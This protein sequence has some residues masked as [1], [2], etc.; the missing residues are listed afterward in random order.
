M[1]QDT[2][3]YFGRPGALDTIKL[4]K[5]G[6]TATRDRVSATYKLAGGGVR[7]SR[8]LSG[9]RTYTL[10]YQTLDYASAAVL[11]AYHCGANGPGPFVLLDPGQRNMLT[12]NQS[13]ACGLTNDTSNFSVSGSGGSITAEATTVHRGT[14]S[15][16]WSFAVTNPASALLSLD[17]P[18]VDWQGIP[19]AIRQHSFGC[20][21][22]GGGS[23]AIVT[24]AAQLVYLNSA[25]ATLSTD[26]GTPVTTN[27]STW[28]SAVVNGGTPPAG[29]CYLSPRISVTGST[30]S[31]GGAIYLSD[32]L[33][34]EG[35]ALDT[36]WSPGTGIPP[37]MVMSLADTQPAY[38]TNY[39]TG[40][41]F[42]LQEVG[43]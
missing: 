29:T 25:G 31:S 40:A 38:A 32:F 37:V 41:T 33:L 17:P 28:V 24:A 34:N 1:A 27:S 21:L 36:A 12:T 35:A 2:T 26:T 22:L 19:C 18:A 16:K 4:P 9:K 7:G 10:S 13:A 20:V 15:L 39:R 14:R 6:L 3:V 11:N 42:V 43:V 30:I 23:D 8:L 5:G